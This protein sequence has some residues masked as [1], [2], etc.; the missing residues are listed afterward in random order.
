MNS[1]K[2]LT[3]RQTAS[4]LQ[5]TQKWVRDL[6]YE[7]KLEGARKVGRHWRIPTAAVDARLR[8]RDGACQR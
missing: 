1:A 6:L 3:V 7:G 5:C 2:A 8:Q 4:K